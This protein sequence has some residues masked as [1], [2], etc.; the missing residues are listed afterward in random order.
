MSRY[1]Q[2]KT[3]LLISFFFLL[4]GVLFCIKV[5]ARNEA[6]P[7]STLRETQSIGEISS[8]F[9]SSKIG[10]LHLPETIVISEING[11]LQA[12]SFA[13]GDE[14]KGGQPLFTLSDDL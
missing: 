8:A 12:I 3:P 11:T 13:T 9:S 5:I 2:R 1:K 10:T 6:T 4:L 7:P 14:I